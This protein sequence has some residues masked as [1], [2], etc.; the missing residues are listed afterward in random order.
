MTDQDLL[1][2]GL[3]GEKSSSPVNR[4][5]PQAKPQHD[6]D[7]T[8]VDT[9]ERLMRRLHGEAPEEDPQPRVVEAELTSARLSSAEIPAGAVTASGGLPFSDFD[10]AAYKA[11][12]MEHQTGEAFFVCALSATEFVVLDRQ[13][14]PPRVDPE[15]APESP[16]KQTSPDL[17]YRD[18]PI[19]EL[20][21]TDFPAEHPVHTCGL[22]RYKKYMKRGFKFKPAY[23][24]M[25]PL[26]LVAALGG[27]VYLFPVLTIELL[28]QDIITQ[29]V[30]SIS[31]EQFTMGVAY[32]GAALGG[33]ALIK[34]LLLRHSHRYMLQDG[35]AKY[36]YGII[37]RETTKIAYS[38]ISNYE[39]KQSILGR[40]LN[41]GDMELASPG[42][43]DS[44]IKM[45]SVLGPRLVEV[46]L[47]GK[48]DEARRANRC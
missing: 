39:V 7:D 21:I 44:E 27:L 14:T 20:K 8:D 37:K 24:S 33:F 3:T 48:I 35:F 30:S 34:I 19:D 26:L 15:Q 5:T 43:N 23:R 9:A 29:I 17:A 10:S 1:L 25:W 41:Y 4:D 38:N 45:N 12:Q 13:A 42:T 16:K 2:V 32:T 6:V 22:A 18:I 47:E 36:E 40:L 11:R 28:P 31:P 46:V